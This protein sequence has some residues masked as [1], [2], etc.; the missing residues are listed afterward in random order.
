[1]VLEDT[2]YMEALGTS[3]A[4]ELEFDN[5]GN[6]IGAHKT[7]VEDTIWHNGNFYTR[8]SEEA[9]LAET[10][11]QWIR[12]YTIKTG[13]NLN[14]DEYNNIFFNVGYISKAPRF[15]NV[16]D[17]SNQLFRDI[18]NEEVKAVEAGYS[19]RSSLS[20]SNRG[21]PPVRS[22]TAFKYN[23]PLYGE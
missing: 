7:M 15:N 6:L 17:Y 4:T 11:W 19:F 13:A 10:K 9:K 3:V 14:L 8:N 21:S 2:T 1:M 23:S 16:Y 18:K 20:I 12:G 5:D 22:S